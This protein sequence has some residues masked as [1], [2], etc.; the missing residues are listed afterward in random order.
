VR[1]A[2]VLL[3]FSLL[4]PQGTVLAGGWICQN[5]SNSLGEVVF[6]DTLK[7][8]T[9]GS[10]STVI[11][12]N[13][14]GKTW[15]LQKSGTSAWL[16]GLCFV[17]SLNGWIVGGG[18]TILHTK[19]G[20][21][22]WESQESGTNHYLCEVTFRDTLNGW[23]VGYGERILHTIDG[24]RNW[25]TQIS[26]PGQR[27]LDDIAFADSLNGWTVGI[28]YTWAQF[29]FPIAYRTTD[30]GWNW[31]PAGEFSGNYS[32]VD[33]ITFADSFNGWLTGGVLTKSHGGLI[34]HTTDGSLNW[35]EQYDLEYPIFDLS[36]SDVQNGWAI[37]YIPGWWE[38]GVVFQTSNSGTTWSQ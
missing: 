22:K 31:E 25:A 27:S 3:I 38:S 14:G 18:G 17:D 1:R 35:E 32:F 21:G 24:G 30:G 20:G 12:T 19:D 2:F 13:D 37:G 23:V 10:N 5:Q 11:H 4:F 26:G 7:G 36:F 9:I 34:M 16:G 28:D 33:V 8:W 6:L 15:A 29:E